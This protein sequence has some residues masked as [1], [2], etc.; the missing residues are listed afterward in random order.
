MSSIKISIYTVICT[1]YTMAKS[2]AESKN[3]LQQ[4]QKN[5][6]RI[7]IFQFD[8]KTS[9]W[10]RVEN[11]MRGTPLYLKKKI[12]L[13]KRSNQSHIH[14]PYNLG[15][16]QS[17]D[18]IDILFDCIEIFNQCLDIVTCWTVIVCKSIPSITQLSSINYGNFNPFSTLHDSGWCNILRAL[19]SFTLNIVVE[20]I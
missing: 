7:I 19:K 12:K 3:E 1:I 20:K 18:G 15:A 10:A 14:D 11:Q 13:Q 5:M 16:H 6:L 8:W 4:G 9:V 2:H 17:S